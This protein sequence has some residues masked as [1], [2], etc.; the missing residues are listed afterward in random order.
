[1]DITL[2]EMLSEGPRTTPKM[3]ITVGQH[4]ADAVRLYLT[5][6]DVSRVVY[7]RHGATV[8]EIRKWTDEPAQ[9]WGGAGMFCGVEIP[10][11]HPNDVADKIDH[12][13]RTAPDM[14]LNNVAAWLA[15]QFEDAVVFAVTNQS[16]QAT[17]HSLEEWQSFLHN[18]YAG[19]PARYGERR[20]PISAKIAREAGY[21]VAKGLGEEDAL[22]L[23]REFPDGAQ[24]D[25]VLRGLTSAFG[26]RASRCEAWVVSK[27][28]V[29]GIVR[30]EQGAYHL[31]LAD[32]AQVYTL[33][34]EEP[35]DSVG[36][37][38]EVLAWV[39]GLLDVHQREVSGGYRGLS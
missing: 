30:W 33:P 17:T 2:D 23:A 14:P 11:V 10:F 35:P 12:M 7:D 26:V 34:V 5:N 22:R 25:A 13:L 38:I 3:E 1:M 36:L 16:P 20:P 37:P 39:S 15:D 9:T 32:A 28:N 29:E 19:G 21:H 8:F 24:P 31:T 27:G 18:I 4:F 6:D